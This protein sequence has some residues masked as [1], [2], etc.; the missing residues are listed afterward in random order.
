MAKTNVYQRVTIIEI[1]IWMEKDGLGEKISWHHHG[2]H[3][4][5]SS[6]DTV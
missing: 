2:P 3:G 1:K 6:F 5:K 4:A